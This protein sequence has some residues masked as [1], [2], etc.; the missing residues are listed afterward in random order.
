MDV[1]LLNIQVEKV[2]KKKY[3][4]IIQSIGNTKFLTLMIVNMGMDMVP[5]LKT[6]YYH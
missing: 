2:F 5:Q 1:I 3:Q 4:N 6:I